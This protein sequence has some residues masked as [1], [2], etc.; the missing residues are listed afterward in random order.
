MIG[1]NISDA[2]KKYS[3]KGER[4]KAESLSILTDVEAEMYKELKGIAIKNRLEQEKIP[5]SYIDKIFM[6]NISTGLEGNG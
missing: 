3:V 6:N 4:N 2:F 1:I 5:Q